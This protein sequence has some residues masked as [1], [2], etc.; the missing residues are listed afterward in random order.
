MVVTRT[1]TISDA[2]GNAST[3]IHTINVNDTTNPVIVACPVTRNIEGCNVGAIFDPPYSP[4][5]TPSI[6]PQFVD[7]I[8]LGL[9]IDVC[10]IATVTYKADA[11]GT[12]PI[13]VTRTWTVR[14]ACGNSA[15][16]NQ[17]INV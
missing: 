9:A 1:W 10:G 16:C 7:P 17:T 11:T 4:V 5:T 6:F 3:C 15:T 2:C 8:N 12:C 13:V 14:D